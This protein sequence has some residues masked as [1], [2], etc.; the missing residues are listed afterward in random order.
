M[1]VEIWGSDTA[2]PRNLA[3]RVDFVRGITDLEGLKVLEAG[4]GEGHYV[5]ALAAAGADVRGIEYLA[6][7]LAAWNRRHPGDDR[8]RFGDLQALDFADESFDLVFMNEVLEHVPDDRR[9][10]AELFRVLKPGGLFVNFTPNRLYPLETHGVIYR[11][12][13]RHVG[14][15]RAPFIPWMPLSL[16]GRFVDFPARNYWPGQLTRMMRDAGFSVRGQ[17]FMWQTFEGAGHGVT[18]A[19]RFAAAARGLARTLEK[20]PGLRRFGI[21]QVVVAVKP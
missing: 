15:L 16:A 12:S 3:K 13:R 10:L 21:S 14:Q 17:S 5:D 11:R 8:V 1:E 7:K 20:T 18:I 9:A 6:D 19:H 4:C 2:T